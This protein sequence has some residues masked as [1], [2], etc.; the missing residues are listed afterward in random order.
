[1][2]TVT[3]V[4]RVI[5]EAPIVMAPQTVAEWTG[6]LAELTDRLDRGRIYDRD[7][8]ALRPAV[9]GLVEAFNRRWT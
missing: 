1:M 2:R 6:L 8:P 3:K 4:Q 7:V 5:I 9:A